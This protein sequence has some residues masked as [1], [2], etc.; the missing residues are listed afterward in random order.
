MCVCVCVCVR[1]CVCACGCSQPT[2]PAHNTLTTPAVRRVPLHDTTRRHIG[3]ISSSSHPPSLTIP[4]HHTPPHALRGAWT[5]WTWMWWMISA[6]NSKTRRPQLCRP[7]HRPRICFCSSSMPKSSPTTASAHHSR[8]PSIAHAHTQ[9]PLSP[10]IHCT[11]IYTIAPLAIYPLH[12]HIHNQI[13][14][15]THIH[16]IYTQA[17]FPS[18][19]PCRIFT[20]H[21]C[22][23]IMPS[24]CCLQ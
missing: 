13:H 2:R 22:V 5:W 17:V 14:E 21:Q 3:M 11:R 4:S 12:T 9:S 24:P 16:T 23:F 19:L 8:H 20:V 18:C 7:R 15:D 1:V 10:S 6:W